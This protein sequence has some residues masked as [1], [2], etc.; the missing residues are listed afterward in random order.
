MNTNHCQLDQNDRPQ[1]N[2]VPHSPRISFWLRR[3]LS[4][5]AVWVAS[6]VTVLGF[7]AAHADLVIPGLE[8]SDGPFNPAED[9]IVD[10]DLAATAPWNT[11]S[12]VQGEGVYDREQWAVVFKYE[13]VHIPPNVTV[14]FKN[15]RSNPPVVW[16]V[17]GDVL[18]EGTVRV[19]AS[20][21]LK[22]AGPGGFR[23]ADFMLLFSGDGQGPGGGN[24]TA[25]LANYGTDPQVNG[26]LRPRYG[27]TR[28]LPLIGGSGGESNS[29]GGPAFGGAGAILVVSVRSLTIDGTITASSLGST[30]S[31]HGGSGGAIRLI[32][33]TVS[34]TGSVEALSRNGGHGRIRIEAVT[35]ESGIMAQPAAT[36]S[37]PDNPVLLW[38][39]E[40]FPSVQIVS[41]N[42]SSAPLDPLG[43][44]DFPGADLTIQ[45]ENETEVMIATENV[46][47]NWTVMLRVV[48]RFLPSFEV[49][50]AYVSGGTASSMWRATVV[51]PVAYSALQVR[52]TAPN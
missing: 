17:S 39:P 44:L 15:H 29:E 47:S 26:R 52:A 36:V 12:T 22:V 24:E 42:S 37:L 45:S 27:N 13:S 20:S 48:P 2:S 43:A 49:P 46:D 6:I 8:P 28:I 7:V 1:P 35:R 30:S 40:T 19:D 51:F 18:I 34:G 16:L 23:G 10:L 11:P 33:E 38:P 31:Y 32:G 4:V 9:L 21:V 5:R 14:T 41:V 25:Q 3:G 50:A